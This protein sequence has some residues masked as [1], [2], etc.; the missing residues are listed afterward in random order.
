VHY[1][2]TKKKKKKTKSERN[3]YDIKKIVATRFL[4]LNTTDIKSIAQLVINH[5]GEGVIMRQAGSQYE[6]GRSL[7]LLKFKVSFSPYLFL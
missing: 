5:A 3:F 4:W 2:F 6:H 7:S 1:I